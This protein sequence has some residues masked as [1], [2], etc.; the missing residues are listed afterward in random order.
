MLVTS[1]V[2]V[3]YGVC[4]VKGSLRRALGVERSAGNEQSL[5]VFVVCGEHSGF[6]G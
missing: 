6:I 5:C 1:V 4:L 2:C 3:A